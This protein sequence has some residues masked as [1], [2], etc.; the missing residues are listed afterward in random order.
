MFIIT[1]PPPPPPNANASTD[2]NTNYPQHTQ[3]KDY[4]EAKFAAEQSEKNR[5]AVKLLHDMATN[6]LTQYKNQL[7]QC[8]EELETANAALA[9]T[10][11]M[12]GSLKLT[13]VN[14]ENRLKHEIERKMEIRGHITE[15]QER[16]KAILKENIVLKRRH[17]EIEEELK[18]SQTS[19]NE[20]RAAL[21]NLSREKVQLKNT[22]K[23]MEIQQDGKEK[24]R[25]FF[26]AQNEKLKQKNLEY[27]KQIQE[28][29]DAA[30]TAEREHESAMEVLTNQY[31]ILKSESEDQIK[32]LMTEV[33]SFRQELVDANEKIKVLAE[34]K[35]RLQLD[36]A[37]KS[38]EFDVMRTESEKNKERLKDTSALADLLEKK[39]SKIQERSRKEMAELQE[40]LTL[41]QDD[42]FREEGMRIDLT[43][44]LAD[45]E[46]KNKY[47]EAANT[48]VRALTHRGEELDQE[49]KE[50][51]K[52][53]SHHV[54]IHMEISAVKE[55]LGAAKSKLEEENARLRTIAAIHTKCADPGELKR[56]RDVDEE[57]KQC[58]TGSAGVRE[59][60]KL[61]LPWAFEPSNDNVQ[62]AYNEEA[63]TQAEP[64]DDKDKKK[65]RL[66][67]GKCSV[68]I[69][70]I[71]GT[72]ITTSIHEILSKLT[73]EYGEKGAS[74]AV[75]EQWLVSHWQGKCKLSS[76]AA[77]LLFDNLEQAGA[78]T[79][80]QKKETREKWE[81][82]GVKPSR[83]EQ[84]SDFF[85]IA[86]RKMSFVD[87]VKTLPQ[88]EGVK[89]VC[90]STIAHVACIERPPP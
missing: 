6:Q 73:D 20:A 82:V 59:E 38:Q 69:K 48:L 77:S 71:L 81:F 68:S 63:L 12:V 33:Q 89:Q 21:T 22:I 28:L 58:Q 72:E 85:D 87:V 34:I 42:A 41:L 35:R 13:V 55:S 54:T 7:Q 43:D 57:H 51:K 46:K 3:T 76:K 24:Q 64:E 75:T 83:Q 49:V 90:S 32:W 65:G 50:L 17:D 10:N 44:A 86:F 5:E 84:K 74:R 31:E 18:N 4:E 37:N 25:Q 26:V 45:I 30:A 88:R 14:T 62:Y 56:L 9:E 2:T 47:L 79:P 52:E 15:I 11:A 66:K 61:V 53:I 16:E 1:H 36:F 23:T 19:Y 78:F 29:Q 80:L 60:L 8:Q 67:S 39:L 40:Q 27:E 70:S